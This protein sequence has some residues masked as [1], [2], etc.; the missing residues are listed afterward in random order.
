MRPFIGYHFFHR[1]GH[2]TPLEAYDR[3]VAAMRQFVNCAEPGLRG[4]TLDMR[5]DFGGP[6]EKVF[7]SLCDSYGPIDRTPPG[8]DVA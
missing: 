8:A 4:V 5:G 7:R 3:T 1:V 2:T 6:L